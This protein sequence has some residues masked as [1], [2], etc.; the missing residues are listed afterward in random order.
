LEFTSNLAEGTTVADAS[1]RPPKQRRSQQSLERVLVAAMALLEEKGFEAFTIQDVSQRADVSV[2]A[3]YARF[4]S[5]E[6]LLRAVHQHAMESIRAVQGAV[7]SADGQGRDAGAVIAAAV[8]TVADVFRHNEQLLGA[9]MHLGA[10]DGVIAKRGSEASIELA[11]GFVET[12]LHHRDEITHADPEK[13]VDVAFRMAYCTFARQVMYGPSFESDRPIGWDELVD[14]VG[15]ACAAYLLQPAR[16]RRRRA[17]RP[18][19]SR[20]SQAA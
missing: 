14:E 17:S 1:V 2:G 13:A 16:P 15:A 8:S 4:G 5:R 10:V 11:R 18:G 9:F 19:A 7:S 3:I 6:N 12:I 20:A